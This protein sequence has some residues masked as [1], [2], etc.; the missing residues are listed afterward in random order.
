[1]LLIIDVVEY[2]NK[3]MSNDKQLQRMG[4]EAFFRIDIDSVGTVSLVQVLDF[5]G[6]NDERVDNKLDD[7]MKKMDGTDNMDW[8]AIDKTD[9]QKVYYKAIELLKINLLKMAERIV[10]PWEQNLGILE[11]IKSEASCED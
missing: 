10:A 3:A 7:E 2:L 9:F 6:H 8:N 11:Q 5:F 4:F 1:M